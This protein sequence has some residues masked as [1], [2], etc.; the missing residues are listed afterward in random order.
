MKVPFVDLGAQHAPIADE[1]K[2]AMLGVLES[3]EYVQGPMVAAFEEEFAAACG[4]AHAVAVNSGTAAL[5]LALLAFGVGPGDEVITVSH[6]FIATAE[7]ISAAGATPVFVDIDPDTYLMDTARLAAAITSRTRAIIPVHLYGQV[8]DM[9]AIRAIADQR[10]IPVVEDA[11][12]AH[13]AIYEERRAGSL[14]AIGCFSFYPSKNLGAIGEGGCAVTDSLTLAA[15]M[16]ALRDHGQSSR[17][18][19]DVVGYNYR[20]A[21]LQGASLRVKLPH[22]DQWNQRRRAHA[23]RYT[24]LLADLP[25]VTPVEA[26]NREH[27]YHLFVIRTAERDALRAHLAACGVATGVHYPVPVHRQKAYASLN[28]PAGA[29]PVTEAVCEQIVSLPM[30]AELTDAHIEAVVDAVASWPALKQLVHS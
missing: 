12:Q 19:H 22:L 27:V 10:G 13:G 2:A 14:G 20:M 6:T 8:A 1:L 21:T 18:Y 29:L 16:R 3:Q 25:V 24:R 11:C 28:Y 9:H 26:P 17:Y 30:Y 4:V 23:R 15:A 5:H 7:A